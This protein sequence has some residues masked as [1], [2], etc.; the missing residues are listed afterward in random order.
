MIFPPVSRF[1]EDAATWAAAGVV[2]NNENR[3]ARIGKQA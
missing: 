1:A 2:T 3:P